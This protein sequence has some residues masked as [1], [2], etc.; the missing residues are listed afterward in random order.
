LA[1]HATRSVWIA[2]FMV[3]SPLPLRRQRAKA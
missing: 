3:V 1:C 2:T